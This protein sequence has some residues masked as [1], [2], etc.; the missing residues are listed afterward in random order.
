MSPLLL[1]LV[2]IIP[3]WCSLGGAEV[4][5]GGG[6]EDPSNH[7]NLET[8]NSKIIYP[9][10][11]FEVLREENVFPRFQNNTV[12]VEIRVKFFFFQGKLAEGYQQILTPDLSDI[13]L[14][15]SLPS[16]FLNE[17]YAQ[18][19]I[20]FPPD[21]P[22]PREHNY[23]NWTVVVDYAD[24]KLM[25]FHSIGSFITQ[26][27]ARVEELEVNVLETTWTRDSKVTAVDEDIFSSLIYLTRLK[28]YHYSSDSDSLGFLHL[29]PPLYDN[30]TLIPV[31]PNMLAGIEP[32]AR[33]MS[34]F[35]DL[36]RWSVASWNFSTPQLRS[37]RLLRI[38]AAALP[39][40]D[41]GT[42]DELQEEREG[43]YGKDQCD[44]FLSLYITLH[45][46]STSHQSS[47]Y[48]ETLCQRQYTTQNVN[49]DLQ[50]RFS[51]SNVVFGRDCINL[52]SIE[53][54]CD[55]PFQIPKGC[56]LLHPN[57]LSAGFEISGF[58]VN[59]Y[60]LSTLNQ[61]S[62]QHLPSLKISNALWNATGILKITVNYLDI[63]IHEGNRHLLPVSSAPVINLDV[64]CGQCPCQWL[65]IDGGDSNRNL[66]IISS[67]GISRSMSKNDGAPVC[68]RQRRMELSNV[69]VDDNAVYLLSTYYYFISELRLYHVESLVNFRA[70][71][72]CSRPI[73]SPSDYSLNGVT[74]DERCIRNASFGMKEIVIETR[75]DTV[76]PFYFGEDIFVSHP[77]LR[78]LQF[79]NVK[80]VAFEP[81]SSQ[82]TTLALVN[83]GITSPMRMFHMNA[84]TATHDDTP[85]V[86]LNGSTTV[87]FDFSYNRISE[88]DLMD[89]KVS[90][91]SFSGI[92][93]LDLSHNIL[94][95][96]N[97]TVFQ[98]MS[99]E[100]CTKCYESTSATT[101]TVN[102][103]IDFPIIKLISVSHNKL[104]SFVIK[105]D[106]PPLG[107]VG[108]RNLTSSTD[109]TYGDFKARFIPKQML[110][111]DLS[112]N[113]VTQLPKDAL[114]K[115][116]SLMYLNLAHNNI[117][118]LNDV[119]LD[120]SSAFR[121]CLVDLS[122]NSLGLSES[123]TLKDALRAPVRSLNLSYNGLKHVPDGLR[124]IAV[125]YGKR[126]TGPRLS[127]DEYFVFFRMY[128]VVDLSHNNIERADESLCGRSSSGQS[129]V[130]ETK[131]RFASGPLYLYIDLSH[132]NLKHISAKALDCGDIYLLLNI[133]HNPIS[134]LPE[135]PK[136]HYRLTLLSA[137]NTSI[138][139][140]PKSYSIDNLFDLRSIY[141]N[142]TYD[143]MDVNETG[144]ST[145]LW[146]CSEIAPLTHV[147][148]NSA[149]KC[150]NVDVV[151]E[152]TDLLASSAALDIFNVNNQKCVFNG[153][154]MMYKQF[155]N[156]SI[157][158]LR[159]G[160]GKDEDSGDIQIS[161]VLIITMLL[162]L[163][164]IL[165]ILLS[166]LAHSMFKEWAVGAMDQRLVIEEDGRGNYPY[167]EYEGGG[168]SQSPEVRG[169]LV[170]ASSYSY[171]SFGGVH[172]QDVD[173]YKKGENTPSNRRQTQVHT[174]FAMNINHYYD[175]PGDTLRL[176][177]DSSH[178]DKGYDEPRD[179]LR[180]FCT[181][182]P[183][184]TDSDYLKIT[185][186]NRT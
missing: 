137:A 39:L 166:N 15:F 120:S 73:D 25:S 130:S 80:I 14:D 28:Y 163:P 156:M 148:K 68:R 185:P 42:F 96:L 159:G 34:L 113:R 67:Y 109:L 27:F 37:L 100:P 82:L 2:L 55:I 176:A 167:C 76:F 127:V 71:F 22:S 119:L 172:A 135:L 175:E 48:L 91:S 150:I 89:V 171:Y 132:N 52:W 162:L 107:Y 36:S 154:I 35:L 84:A 26:N 165:T 17:S 183:I 144:Q 75:N 143:G 29:P 129:D 7:A 124:Q 70:L 51:V 13:V 11:G 112:H 133:N 54:R 43:G 186:L 134:K 141:I 46:C 40:P 56:P 86:F 4:P 3:P 66:P 64:L 78:K 170:W 174:A 101:N 131:A 128:P 6:R 161:L 157:H 182:N 85:S 18:N 180:I 147:V 23:N 81:H 31:Y 102:L 179:A 38:Q 115:L 122:Y 33:L 65:R 104:R 12:F 21:L 63:R 116:A 47:L 41:E 158:D 138:V 61:A 60:V 118:S 160:I 50:S 164:Y 146:G 126:Y 9:W 114:S 88:F 169:S 105:D 8:L 149:L 53:S 45:G 108:E 92:R 103:N 49:S 32:N 72:P 77:N 59:N 79:K 184:P 16:T 94:T 20:K 168:N 121:G 125:N 117:S 10:Y 58:V 111:I 98:I 123:L 153:K 19:K 87:E 178:N 5:L 177:G 1:F 44:D 152:R 142:S 136:K 69:R 74:S 106:L 110:T 181:S 140:I 93:K 90:G 155:S 173:K 95:K 97:M 30:V 62:G 145:K 24:I 99:Y 151:S 57:L 139:H 83:A